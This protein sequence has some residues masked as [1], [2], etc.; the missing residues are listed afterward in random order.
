MPRSTFADRG[1]AQKRC[2]ILSQEFREVK[3]FILTFFRA[4]ML[5]WFT[6][7]TVNSA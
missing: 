6:R 7:F 2:D 3:P 4:D 5:R 1:I